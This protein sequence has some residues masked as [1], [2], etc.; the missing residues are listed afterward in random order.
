[1]R[2]PNNTTG[3]GEQS[4]EQFGGTPG[5]DEEI[6][7]DP[8]E[9]YTRNVE[10]MC[11][12]I[13]QMGLWLNWNPGSRSLLKEFIMKPE[14]A[15]REVEKVKQGIRRSDQQMVSDTK[16]TKEEKTRK[17]RDMIH[18]CATDGSYLNKLLDAK[19]CPNLHSKESK[20][21]GVT[22]FHKVRR[23]T[24]HLFSHQRKNKTWV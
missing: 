14:E 8:V 2:N 1:M 24:Q 11:K 9:V 10:A 15:L 22:P 20:W 17:V 16:D 21:T 5:T 7:E 18:E 6:A 13:D 4:D 12:E 3:T 23:G 19:K